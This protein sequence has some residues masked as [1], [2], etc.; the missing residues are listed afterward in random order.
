MFW[1]S[2][3]LAATEPL[4]D[5]SSVCTI[6]TRT[7]DDGFASTSSVTTQRRNDTARRFFGPMALGASWSSLE[8][9]VSRRVRHQSCVSLRETPFTRASSHCC[10]Q[11]PATMSRF[12]AGVTSAL[13]IHKMASRVR[14][15]CQP[16]VSDRIDQSRGLRSAI[17]IA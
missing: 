8:T 10:S 15:G 6:P 17:A 7:G 16:S 13:F 5:I 12:H 9:R 14:V 3:S 11:L 4:A 2:S 1:S